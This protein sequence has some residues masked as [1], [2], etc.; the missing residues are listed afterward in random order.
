MSKVISQKRFNTEA[1][2]AHNKY[3]KLHFVPEVQL[4]DE[5]TEKALQWAERLAENGALKYKNPTFKN[6]LVGENILRAKAYYLSGDECTNEWYKEEA[7]YTYNGFFKQSTGHFTQMVWKNTR[8]VGFAYAQTSDGYFYVV[9]NYFPAG[10][11][12]NEFTT[13]VLKPGAL[14][15]LP[16]AFPAPLTSNSKQP[17]PRPAYRDEPKNKMLNDDY[18]GTTVR[19]PEIAYKDFSASKPQQ[20]RAINP[21]SAPN[22][23]ISMDKFISEALH[24][25]N[26]CRKK[27]ASEPL[28]HNPELSA[29][30][31]NYANHLAKIQSLIHSKNTYQG[32]KLGENLYFSYDSTSSV[33]SGE[34]PTIEWY[35]E[36]K[37]Y[38]YNDY[39]PGTGH[40]TQVVW[41]A[42]KEVGFGL[43][44]AKNG[45]IYVVAN[46]YPPGNYLNKFSE[47]VKR[48]FY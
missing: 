17:D 38:K 2:D 24:A 4:S 30:A 1:L 22:E 13:N 21:R 42:T 8:L 43:A 40:F 48:P 23:E 34:K 18:V 44:K 9:A 36:I 19:Q 16:I 37:D 14:E 33:I 20:P 39:Q 31:Q 5:L 7:D 27:H 11:Y 35:N 45:S 47:N 6:D 25:H 29:I 15:N 32:Q 10:N 3:R 46:Y 26:I 12:K 41:K 28:V